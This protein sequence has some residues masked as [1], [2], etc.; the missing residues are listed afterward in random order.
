M[1]S[2]AINNSGNYPQISCDKFIKLMLALY[3][4]GDF[5]K[6]PTKM[7]WGQPGIGKSQAVQQFAENLVF[8]QKFFHWITCD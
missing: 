2:L 6:Q 7:L 8:L 4:D 5:S 1:A 3:G